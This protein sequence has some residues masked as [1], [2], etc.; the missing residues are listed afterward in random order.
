[1]I[2]IRLNYLLYTEYIQKQRVGMLVISKSPPSA[3][4]C[5]FL[6]DIQ[7]YLFGHLTLLLFYSFLGLFLVLIRSNRYVALMAIVPFAERPNTS[8]LLFPN[9][10]LSP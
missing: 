2:R 5:S 4:G 10:S 9:T 8:F 1:M 7:I 6:Q 3:F